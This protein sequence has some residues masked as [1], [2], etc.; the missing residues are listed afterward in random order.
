MKS[1]DGATHC[2]ASTVSEMPT[3]DRARKSK[4]NGNPHPENQR[5]RPTRTISHESYTGRGNYIGELPFFFWNSIKSEFFPLCSRSHIQGSTILRVRNG[6]RCC[7]R[8]RMRH[9]SYEV[10]CEPPSGSPTELI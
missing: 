10:S 3:P 9:V 4:R 8:A 1:D 5:I 7:G 6:K 2:L